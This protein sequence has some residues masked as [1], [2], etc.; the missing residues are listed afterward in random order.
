MISDVWV[1]RSRRNAFSNFLPKAASQAVPQAATL[2]GCFPCIF[3]GAYHAVGRFPRD[4]PGGS[5]VPNY[6]SE[7]RKGQTPPKACGFCS[8]GQCCA[9]AATTAE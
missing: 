8:A 3:R 7:W 2:E 4:F 9:P 5:F 1:D 6:M